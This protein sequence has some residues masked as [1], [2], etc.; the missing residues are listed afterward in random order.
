MNINPI[1]NTNFK[2]KYLYLGDKKILDKVAKDCANHEDKETLS[3]EHNALLVAT[4]NDA[5]TLRKSKKIPNFQNWIK[6]LK[7]ICGDSYARNVCKFIFKTDQGVVI[8][9]ADK[10]LEPADK[11]KEGQIEFI[12]NTTLF[13]HDKKR[14]AKQF[15]DGR[16]EYYTEEGKVKTIKYP[17]G[18]RKDNFY[19]SSCKDLLFTR[20]T[21]APTNYIDPDNITI[22]SE[23]G[24]ANYAEKTVTFIKPNGAIN[25]YDFEGRI[26]ATEDIKEANPESIFKEPYILSAINQ[27]TK[28]KH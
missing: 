8:C 6:S 12:D 5:K 25:I 19:N 15:E 20:I 27:S 4:S 24:I 28:N 10:S 16:I 18:S 9:Q 3:I 11:I 17:D 21:K 23:E 22:V 13:V 26:I 7:N 1:G 2:A 14:Y